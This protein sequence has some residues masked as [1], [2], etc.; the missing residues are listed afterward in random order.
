MRLMPGVSSR[1]PDRLA[2]GHRRSSSKTDA[3]QG[4]VENRWLGFHGVFEPFDATP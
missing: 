4:S 2:A 3:P 1:F